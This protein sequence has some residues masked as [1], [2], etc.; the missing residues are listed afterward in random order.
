MCS[1]VSGTA[2]FVLLALILRNTLGPHPEVSD[3]DESTLAERVMVTEWYDE[4]EEGV[5]GYKSM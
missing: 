4:K 3:D 1:Q 2:S 5:K